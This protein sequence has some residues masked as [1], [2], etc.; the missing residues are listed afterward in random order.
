MAVKKDLSIDFLG[1]HCENPF[2]LSSS[3]VG[4]DFNMISKA[5]DT[6]WCGV[7]CKTIGIVVSDECSPRFATANREGMPWLGLKNLDQISDKPTEYNFEQLY[8]L[9]KAY[10]HK[11]IVASIMGSSEEEWAKLA[12]MCE[13][14]GVDLIEGNLSC[15]QM[16]VEGCGCDVGSN[17]D[18][19]RKFTAAVVNTTKI[20]FIA[21][22][23]PNITDITVPARAA[24]ESG[25]AGISAINTIRSITNIDL[26]HLTA[27][28]V[29]NGKGSIS[30][31]SGA[32]IKPIA[33][34]F[35]QNLMSDPLISKVPVSGIG[36]IETWR[37]AVEFLL[38][39]CRNLQVTTSVMQYGYRVVEDMKNGLMHYMDEHGFDRLED[40]IGLA[41]GGVVSP[42]ELDRDYFLY[43]DFDWDK[44]LGCGRCYVSCYDGAHQAI[45]WDAEKRRPVFKPERCVGCHLCLNVC[46][47]NGVITPGE[48]KFKEGRSAHE[49]LRQ[50][51]YD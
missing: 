43:P 11:V 51:H 1:V 9:K 2:F 40:F 44:C 6:G 29:V 32:A 18:M 14:V 28:P 4:A 13:Q 39:G 20:P 46:P 38:L 41:R 26:D 27:L 7:M 33:L 10:P 31:Y 24:I 16:T 17:P 22:M 19:V 42:D 49:V 3:P 21:K 45:K 37:D 48:T 23:T 8:K 25:A 47:V 36:G 5:F 15:P 30:G 12:K 50:R 34:R 35:I